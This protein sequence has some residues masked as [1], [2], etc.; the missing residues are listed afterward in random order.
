VIKG[1]EQ[2]RHGFLVCLLLRRNPAR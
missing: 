2:F 1:I